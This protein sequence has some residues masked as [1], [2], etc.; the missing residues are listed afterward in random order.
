MRKLNLEIK[1]NEIG[2]KC[3]E[4][5]CA[6][7]L[8]E[9]KGQKRGSNATSTCF[10]CA[11]PCCKNQSFPEFRREEGITVCTEC[12]H[13]CSLDHA[14]DVLVA[15]KEDGDALFRLLQR[16]CDIKIVLH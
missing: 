12:Q 10:T 8:F 11:S 6:Y 4:S 1:C 16:M 15:I 13:L 2:V 3:D 14:N 7:C 9:N 5:K